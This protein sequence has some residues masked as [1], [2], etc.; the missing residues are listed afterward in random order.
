MS[1]SYCNRQQGA[2][3][4]GP[5][6]VDPAGLFTHHFTSGAWNMRLFLNHL[7]FI[8]RKLEN[9]GLTHAPPD[10]MEELYNQHSFKVGTQDKC[11]QLSTQPS[12][13]KKKKKKDPNLHSV[14]ELWCRLMP[15]KDKRIKKNAWPYTG[16]SRSLASRCSRKLYS[17]QPLTMNCKKVYS[18]VLIYTVIS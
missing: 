12:V 6:K 13:K 2:I 4:D 7:Q 10:N 8:P 18:I 11:H 9:G 15:W 16:Y 17:S 1:Q 14:S 3:C 5:L